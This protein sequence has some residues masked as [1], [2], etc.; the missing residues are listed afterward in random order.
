MS[1]C[2]TPIEGTKMGPTCGCRASNLTEPTPNQTE[3]RKPRLS[4]LLVKVSQNENSQSK[5][6]KCGRVEKL[7]SE[8]F[9]SKLQIT[10]W[11]YQEGRLA[12]N[13]S[14]DER[15]HSHVPPASCGLRSRLLPRHWSQP[16]REPSTS[17][18]PANIS[19]KT[20]VIT[21]L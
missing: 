5:F 8:D 21:M 10:S 14:Q 15:S 16:S 3:V 1:L 6:L 17:G 2:S 12:S 18:S 4:W 20:S 13:S 7:Q 9:K 19:S 11:Q